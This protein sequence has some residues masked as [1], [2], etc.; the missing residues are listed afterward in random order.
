[1]TYFLYF[2]LIYINFRHFY[3]PIS[4][5][6]VIL[7]IKKSQSIKDFNRN[8]KENKKFNQI[9][10]NQNLIKKQNSKESILNLNISGLR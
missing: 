6:K 5:D 10:L 2:H 4:T 9:I 8:L 7:P 3:L 1:M